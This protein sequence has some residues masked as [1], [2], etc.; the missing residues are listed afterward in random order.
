MTLTEGMTIELIVGVFA[1]GVATVTGVFSFLG[2]RA[3]RRARDEITNNHPV[4][5][6]DDLTASFDK[7]FAWMEASDRHTESVDRR[8]EAGAQR[9]DQFA[10]SM[11]ILRSY[12]GRT[13]ERVLDHAR[14]LK[15][16]TGTTTE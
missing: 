13:D 7:V 14:A 9:M 10:E 8:I 15:G 6:R 16:I 4:N 3:A 5:I 1:L 12:L 11:N 2:Q